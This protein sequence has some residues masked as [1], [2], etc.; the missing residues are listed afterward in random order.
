MKRKEL[1]VKQPSGKIYGDTGKIEDELQLLGF[2]DFE[3]KKEFKQFL[4]E[5][6]FE[7]QD[8]LKY[9]IWIYQSTEKLYV[10]EIDEVL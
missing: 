10:V 6:I 3:S 9:K 7:Y 5:T 8:L 1:K 4:E 2:G